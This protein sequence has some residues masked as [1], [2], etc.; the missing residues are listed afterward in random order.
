MTVALE[1]GPFLAAVYDRRTDCRKRGNI[2]L[3]DDGLLAPID[4]RV[5]ALSAAL[6]DTVTFGIRQSV[7]RAR[8]EAWLATYLP[9]TEIA[10][11]SA[12]T[13]AAYAGLRLELKTRGTPIPANDAWIA[14]LTLQ[15]CLPLLSNDSHFDV[16]PDLLRI[17]F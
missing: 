7:Q 16:V 2:I 4:L 12:V 5:Q 13:A 6:S 15:L 17:A 8:Y 1:F 10:I 11:L 3:M 14:A 9:M